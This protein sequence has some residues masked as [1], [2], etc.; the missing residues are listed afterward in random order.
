VLTGRT[1]LPVRTRPNGPSKKTRKAKEEHMTS[2]C[3]MCGSAVGDKTTVPVQTY[4][5]PLGPVTLRVC[6]VCGL[7][8]SHV[9]ENLDAYAKSETERYGGIPD[10]K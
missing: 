10:G 5:H 2:F 6:R 3:S 9:K 4:I 7:I 8:T 1:I